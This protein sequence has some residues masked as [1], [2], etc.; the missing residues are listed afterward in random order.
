MGVIL[1]VDD[2]AAIRTALEVLFDVHGLPAESVASPAEAIARVQRGGVAVVVQDMNYTESATSGEEGVAL[3]ERLR[4]TDPKLPI[5][6]LTAWTSLETA[7]RLVKAGAA[8][9]LAK[10]WDD[11]KLVTTVQN[12]LSIRSLEEENGRLRRAAAK[13]HDLCG[14][15]YASPAMHEVVMLALQ[16][17]KSEVPVLITGPNGSGKEKLAEIIQ[18]NSKRREKPFVR[19]NA[20]ALPE[21]LLEAE[22]F[23]AEAG[24]FTGAT[25]RQ[26]RFEAADGGTLFLDELGNLSLAG[27][28]KLL[29]VLQTGEYQRLG[30]NATRTCDVRLVS[31][32][33]ADLK[34]MI[35]EKTFREDLYFRVNVIELRIPSLADRRDDILPL[36]ESFLPSVGNRKL[37]VSAR[38]AL[39][40]YRWPGNVRELHNRLRRASLLAGDVIEERDL[41]LDQDSI[42]PPREEKE[43]DRKT[44]E[45]AIDKHE[46][47]IARAA[48]ELGVSRQA[49]YRR[50]EKLGITLERR[51]RG[52]EG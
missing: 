52:S 45:E 36:A 4:A 25:K 37:A 13:D 34:A 19:V 43:L 48:A 8:D 12:L 22:L 42:K 20:G 10:P 3:F 24:A 38:R 5:L 6:L 15:V 50:M 28:M 9:Y 2:Q 35:S 33:N 40:A 46:G 7:V 16:V 27:Q 26:G 44:I 18:A 41:A 14:V 29:R 39:L 21:N 23:G 49:L 11:E 30:S 1:I 47:K 17:A 51:V 32:T 31:A